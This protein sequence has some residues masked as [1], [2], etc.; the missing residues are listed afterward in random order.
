MTITTQEVIA[1]S[2]DKNERVI[3]QNGRFEIS[4][5]FYQFPSFLDPNAARCQHRI[6]SLLPSL[7]K[8]RSLQLPANDK[9]TRN[10]NDGK[11]Y[12]AHRE[13]TSIHTASAERPPT[14][15]A[16]SSGEFMNRFKSVFFGN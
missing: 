6:R 10:F 13:N 9:R 7:V 5:A 14:T 16:T 15:F 11:P 4:Y 2:S 8:T 3:R 1:L 12:L